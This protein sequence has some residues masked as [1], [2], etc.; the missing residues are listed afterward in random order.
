V[1]EGTGPAAALAVVLPK[2]RAVIGFTTPPPALRTT[3]CMP[4][5]VLTV[6]LVRCIGLNGEHP[7]TY[8]KIHVSDADTDY[9]QRSKLVGVCEGSGGEWLSCEP[10]TAAAAR[11]G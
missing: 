8:C 4:Q 2:P 5:G 11:T 7:N 9:T 10:S 3:L 6:H 1:H